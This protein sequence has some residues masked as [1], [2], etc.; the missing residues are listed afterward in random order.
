MCTALIAFIS[1]MREEPRRRDEPRDIEDI[2][3]VR[4]SYR[5]MRV[6]MRKTATVERLVNS[7]LKVIGAYCVWVGGWGAAQV[8]SH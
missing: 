8:G 6:M 1:R 4:R 5:V 2:D 3:A 7:R